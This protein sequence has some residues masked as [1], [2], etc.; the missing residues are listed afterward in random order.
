MPHENKRHPDPE[1]L[2]RA[3]AEVPTPFFLYDEKTIVQKCRNVLALQN[4]FGLQVYYAMKANANRALLQLITSQGLNLDLSSLNEGRRAVLASIPS[5]RMILTSQDIPMGENRKEMEEMILRGLKYNVCSLR[6]LDLISDFAGS[7]NIPLAIRIHPGVGSG[8]TITRNTGD[9]YS[10][11]GIHLNDVDKALEIAVERGLLIDTVHVHIGSGGDS[12]EWRENIDRELG[13]VEK[14]FPTVTTVNLGGG[15][16]EARMPD[17]IPAD[18][19]DLGRYARERFEQFF[20]RTGRKLK[21]AVEP[22]TYIMANAGFLVTRVLDKKSTGPAGY[23]FLILDGGMDANTRPLL[24]GSKHPFY[25]ISKDGRLL[26][27]EFDRQKDSSES[28]VVAGRCCETGDSQ[29]L[30]ALGHVIPR[31]M[32]APENDDFVVIGGVG[33]YCS[34]M[35]LANYNSYFQSPEVL[36]RQ[37]GEIQIIRKLQTMEQIVTNECPL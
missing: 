22:G 8:E 3:T 6:Q 28:F 25:V 37:S 4:A 9:K 16:K 29:T 21:M 32:A 10:S 14:Y 30:D 1:H 17:E 5:D 2:L 33:A 7:H 20:E 31:Q 15:F 18:L 19:D 26:S 27:S 13:F 12:R 36:L 24:Y 35:S 11:F 34:A 23:K